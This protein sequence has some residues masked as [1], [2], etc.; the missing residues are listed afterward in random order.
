MFVKSKDFVCSSRGSISALS[1]DIIQKRHHIS[2]KSADTAMLYRIQWKKR[3]LIILFV[4]FNTV[5]YSQKKLI[6]LKNEPDKIE[7]NDFYISKVIDG[8]K[9][10][11]N[12]G[13]IQIGLFNK[14]IDADLAGGVENSIYQYLQNSFSFDTSK[15]PIVI[16][17]AHL[18]ISEKTTFTNEIGRA[19]IKL[20]FY[21]VNN[22]KLGKIYETEAFVEESGMDVTRGHEKR[23]RSVLKT[24]I[25][26]FNNS[27]WKSKKPE[28]EEM[29]S[30]IADK[31]DVTDTSFSG[32][33]QKTIQWNS[34][35]TFNKTF[36][37]NATGWGLSYY[38]YTKTGMS[39]WIIP[40]VVS[41]ENFTI[42]TDYF[43][44]FE[45]QEAK[46]N[47]WM[48]GISAFKKLNDNFYANLT[49]LIPI[50]N[51]TLTDFNGKE[52]ENFLIGLAP[53]QG[54]YFIPKSNSG[55]TFGIGIYECLLTSEVYKSDF[56]FKAEIGIKF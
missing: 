41:I 18:N 38:R 25:N 28:F 47:Y 29:E 30:V 4:I 56:G 27:N 7:I 6:E 11:E 32:K 37:I 53:T 55:I 22:G 2:T 31:T 24:C 10:Q 12:I 48:P 34:L 42:N 13:F 46:L 5:C 49:F 35:L 36:G 8:R 16:K 33:K 15:T 9:N 3:I 19:E 52:T 17:I 14:K 44:Q 21:K 39:N 45:Y 43:S 40:W 26:S 20:E 50:G 54:I 51:E 1:M 23:I